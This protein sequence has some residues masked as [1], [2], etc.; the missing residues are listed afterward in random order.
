MVIDAGRATYPE[1]WGA[2]IKELRTSRGLTVQQF[3]VELGV[4]RQAVKVWEN[5]NFPP[6]DRNRILIA[7]FFNIPPTILFDLRLDDEPLEAA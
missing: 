5:G 3:A 1:R 6:S 2:T 7:R 4:S